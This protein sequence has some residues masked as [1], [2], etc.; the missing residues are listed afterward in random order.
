MIWA[1]CQSSWPRECHVLQFLR[2]QSLD[3]RDKGYGILLTCLYLWSYQWGQWSL[4]HMPD[5][6]QGWSNMWLERRSGRGGGVGAGWGGGIHG[7]NHPDDPNSIDTPVWFIFGACFLTLAVF[8][9]LM[10]FLYLVVREN[11]LSLAEKKILTKVQET[12][13]RG[14]TFTFPS[15]TSQYKWLMPCCIYTECLFFCYQ[16]WSRNIYIYTIYVYINTHTSF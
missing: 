11:H 14:K 2:P 5:T 1:W 8:L 6:L 7:L 13:T 4:K 9:S 15:A 3:P 16:S 10:T 12:R